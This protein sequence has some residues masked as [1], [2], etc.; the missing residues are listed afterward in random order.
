MVDSGKRAVDLGPVKYEIALDMMEIVNQVFI[1]E[2]RRGGGSWKRLAPSTIE[3]K[4]HSAIL[5][6]TGQLIES[7][8]VPGAEHQVLTI[9]ESPVGFEF[10]TD[11]PWAFVHQYGSENLVHEIPA[12]PFLKFR[13]KDEQNWRDMIAT[14]ILQPFD[15]TGFHDESIPF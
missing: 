2:G 9:D 5:I 4:G 8:T 6:D 7:L 3:K 13:E 12:R 11:R 1:S 15:R 14:H 10:G